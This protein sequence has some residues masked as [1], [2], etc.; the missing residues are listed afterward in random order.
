[1]RASSPL[2]FQ[3]GI[4]WVKKGGVIIYLSLARPAAFAVQY[5]I[6]KE[7]NRSLG[8][9]SRVMIVSGAQG[10]VAQDFADDFVVTRPSIEQQLG[11]HMPKLMGRQANAGVVE[12]GG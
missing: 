3:E 7:I 1:V 12:Q 2:P 10:F 9:S 8:F 5:H 6:V 4:K 11:C